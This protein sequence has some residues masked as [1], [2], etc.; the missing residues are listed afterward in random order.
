MEGDR[1]VRDGRGVVWRGN[2]RMLDD[3]LWDWG[4]RRVGKRVLE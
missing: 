1:G 2:R 4:F 3:E